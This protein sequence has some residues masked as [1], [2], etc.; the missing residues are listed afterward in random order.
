MF[1]GTCV[2]LVFVSV[3]GLVAVAWGP[4]GTGDCQQPLQLSA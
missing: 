4:Y 3:Y 2:Q 1:Q